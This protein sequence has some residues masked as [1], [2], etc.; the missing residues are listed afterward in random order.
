MSSQLQLNQQNLSEEITHDIP[1]CN[2]FL[3]EISDSPIGRTDIID[4]PTVDE[5]QR[6]DEVST[7]K[8]LE[9]TLKQV[10]KAQSL[11]ENLQSIK[12]TSQSTTSIASTFSADDVILESRRNLALHLWKL[13]QDKL[14]QADFND[15]STFSI[16]ATKIFDA[17][18]NL[19]NIDVFPLR[20]MTQQ[21][22]S[23]IELYLPLKSEFLSKMTLEW[24]NEQLEALAIRRNELTL[25]K[26]SATTEVELL[27][28][29]LI[30]TCSKFT[31]LQEELKHLSTKMAELETS[32]KQKEYEVL[33]KEADVSSVCA[34]IRVVETTEV[35]DEDTRR[36]IK[37]MQEWLEYS[38]DELRNFIWKP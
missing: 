19:S 38:R 29:D 2:D 16:E 6:K 28:S 34:E 15:A 4:I 17:I 7:S 12:E 25:I 18:A 37:L 14:G 11:Q 31:E 22:F 23:K 5:L 30:N 36:T 35:Q 26:D 13:L 1:D 32:I 10:D 20:D 24:K 27:Q 33:A 3:V 9:T 21:Y 8:P